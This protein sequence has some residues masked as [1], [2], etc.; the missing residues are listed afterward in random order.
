MNNI[1][2]YPV[3]F[4]LCGVFKALE[5]NP[6]AHK[7]SWSVSQVNNNEKNPQ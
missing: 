2:S 1:D 6:Q 7:K 3:Y 5:K 4:E